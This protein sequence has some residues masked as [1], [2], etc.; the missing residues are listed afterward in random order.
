MRT[1]AEEFLQPCLLLLLFDGPGHGCELIRRLAVRRDPRR[2]WACVSGLRSLESGGLVSS[3]RVPSDTAPSRRVYD[4]TRDGRA[5][6]EDW[7]PELL[8]PCS[9]AHHRWHAARKTTFCPALDLGEVRRAPTPL[10]T[11]L[12]CRDVTTWPLSGTAALASRVLADPPRLGPVR[13]V[14]VDGPAGSGKT[15]FAAGLAAAL[16]PAPVVHMD[17]LY[18][19]WSGLVDGVWGRLEQQVLAPLRAG[20]PGRYQRY[21][22]AAGQFAGWVD[23]P[24]SAALV[25]EGVGSAALPVDPWAVLRVWVEAPQEV[26]MARGVE[27]DGEALRDEWARWTELEAA[28]FTADGTRS[29]ADLLVDGLA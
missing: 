8:D 19:G 9:G 14:V 20:R 28:H 15:T 22:W 6:L 13:L 3:S 29:R 10:A 18:E 23:V 26:R 17:D 4:I 2:L 25:V 16:R 5:A 11:R 1:T 24:V 21:D 27:R 7:T 12:A